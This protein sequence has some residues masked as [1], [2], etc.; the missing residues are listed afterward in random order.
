MLVIHNWYTDF[1][2][3]ALA[4]SE[5]KTLT[6]KQR[7][8]RAVS[9]LGVVYDAKL[10]KDVPSTDGLDVWGGL[11]RPEVEQFIT[12]VG[13]TRLRV[14]CWF[15]TVALARLFGSAWD[16]HADLRLDKITARPCQLVLDLPPVQ[17]RQRR[18]QRVGGWL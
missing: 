14:D 17:P 3:V 5:A 13:E 2:Y 7:R 4:E 8:L 10:S 15:G 12:A 18:T 1:V 6:L 11:W 16:T 9:G